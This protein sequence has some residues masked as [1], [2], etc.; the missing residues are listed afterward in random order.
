MLVLH[1][2]IDFSILDGIFTFVI[3]SMYLMIHYI[4]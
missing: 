1:G 3:V 4:E 2:V